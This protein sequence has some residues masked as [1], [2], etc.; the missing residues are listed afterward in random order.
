MFGVAL[1]GIV[2]GQITINFQRQC[3]HS[4]ISNYDTPLLIVKTVSRNRTSLTSHLI[5]ATIIVFYNLNHA[6]LLLLQ[7]AEHRNDPAPRSAS[8][9]VETAGWAHWLFGSFQRRLVRRVRSLASHPSSDAE[10]FALPACGRAW[11]MLGSRKNSKR[12]KCSKKPQ[13]P[14]RQ[15]HALLGNHDA[16][17]NAGY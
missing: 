17:Q 10:R 1:L 8:P 13:N 14:T 3:I 6:T 11:I 4:L 16:Y 5:Q 15:V 2:H 7:V 12:E 9:M